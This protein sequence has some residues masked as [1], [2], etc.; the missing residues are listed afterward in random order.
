[1]EL[2]VIIVSFNVRYYL[3]QCLISVIKASEN[4]DYEIFVID[5]NS[6]D[7]SCLMI[8]KEFPE[9]VLIK[10]KTN[11]GFSAANN[12]AIKLAKG[13]FI[14]LLNPDTLVENDTFTKCINFIDT[15]PDAGAVGVRMINGE[16]KFLRESKRSLPTPGTAFFKTFGFSYLFPRSRLFNMYYLSHI[17]SF[18]TC[19]ADVISGAFMFMRRETLN[20][21][22]L[23][24]EDFFMFG[25]DI[26]L[27]Y[28]F[29]Q[30]G[31]NNYYFPDAQIVH[32]KGRS[33][34]K[35]NSSDLLHFYKA[36]RIYLWKRHS[37]GKLSFWI[38]IIT[39]AIYF[40]EGLALI[41]RFLRILFHRLS[42]KIKP[43]HE[44]FQHA[45]DI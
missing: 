15:H 34:A 13:R 23:L 45:S 5:N 26:D 9:I 35:D 22:G 17:D 24:D 31:Y 4:I 10:N 27:S 28:R 12:K 14:L 33:S 20:K 16:G 1:M 36:M 44:L 3:K 38:Y 7:D 21:T 29:S 8:E 43:P 6:V 39:P 2:S 40:R 32:F 18:E 19:Q 25:E 42:L 41:N 37:E 11:I 30:A